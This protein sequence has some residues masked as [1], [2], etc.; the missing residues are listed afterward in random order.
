MAN[1]L[2]PQTPQGAT[3]L[4]VPS[5][6][7]ILASP[8]STSNSSIGVGGG[9]RPTLKS[10][11]SLLTFAPNKQTTPASSA[12]PNAG[13]PS[14]STKSPFSNFGSVRRSMNLSREKGKV[15][16][17]ERK[18][19]WSSA[20]PVIAI[21]HPSSTSI[22]VTPTPVRKSL[23]LSTFDKST[24]E[25]SRRILTINNDHR[26]S[27]KQPVEFEALFND[28]KPLP[29]T[30]SSPQ[31]MDLSTIIEADTSGISKHLPSASDS[32]P[33]SPSRLPSQSPSPSPFY[34]PLSHHVTD[35]NED[36]HLEL[37]LSTSQITSQVAYEWLKDVNARVVDVDVDD[38]LPLDDDAGPPVRG[39]LIVNLDTVD[40]ALAALLS[41]HKI[42]PG[43][44]PGHTDNENETIVL[45][46]PVR[47]NYPTLSPT[48]QVTTATLH[49]L[50]QRPQHQSSLP[51]LRP[52]QYS[53]SSP[54][55]AADILK[56]TS[57]DD[58]KNTHSQNQA[59]IH[60]HLQEH[61]SSG[62]Q[63][64]SRSG[65]PAPAF[66]SGSSV[67]GRLLPPSANPPTFTSNTSALSSS[68][69]S[70]SAGHPTPSM[71]TASLS[72]MYHRKGAT[73]SSLH[74]P[75]D[76]AT[77]LNMHVNSEIDSTSPVRRHQRRNLGLGLP[78]SSSPSSPLSTR[79]P[80]VETPARR[81]LDSPT[82]SPRRPYHSTRLAERPRSRATVNEHGELI[83]GRG[84]L[85]L[86]PS[87]RIITSHPARSSTFEIRRQR[88]RSM[89][90]EDHSLFSSLGRYP[91]SRSGA[92][93]SGTSRPEARPSSSL[94]FKHTDETRSSSRPVTEWLGPRTAKAFRAA[95]LLGHDQDGEDSPSLGLT[96]TR[97]YGSIR[98][99][100]SR[101]QSGT[102]SRIEGQRRGSGSYFS[103][104]SAVGM[105]SP[106][107]TISSSRGEREWPPRSASTAP[108]SVSGISN[109]REREREK[110]ES[111]FETLKEK[112]AVET[113]ALLSALADSQRTTKVLREENE[114]LRE[115]L[116]EAQRL[117][118]VCDGLRGELARVEGENE[119]LKQF[120][121]DYVVREGD[122]GMRSNVELDPRRRTQVF[123]ASKG[124][125]G[126][127]AGT[128]SFRQA[129]R[130]A[131]PQSPSPPPTA[132]KD[133]FNL[134]EHPCEVDSNREYVTS[135]STPAANRKSRR[136]STASS[137]IF[138]APPANMTMLNEEKLAPSAD[139]GGY[140]SQSESDASG[141]NSRSIPWNAKSNRDTSILS[142]SNFSVTT[143]SPSSLC[144]RPE[145]E[146]HLGD[147]DS[148]DFG[149]GVANHG[150]SGD[151]E[152]WQ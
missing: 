84:S 19:S 152:E 52:H 139:I 137:S 111:A 22:E 146:L 44:V 71:S 148:L 41:P 40:P 34:L 55:L 28:S 81:S 65:A 147:M 48:T 66:S 144:L 36:S 26:G 31:Q 64:T 87:P 43:P 35:V 6:S 42:P 119:R 126:R 94:S 60:K 99:T 109:G 56:P 150:E 63:S 53:S 79:K 24:E 89:S 25:D 17:R 103:G 11:R 14:G 77:S 95:G 105:E 142:I 75:S 128:G 92:G 82:T 78:F 15:Q 58:V 30:P 135:T 132:T 101:T 110:E 72:T 62:H 1:S 141:S 120:V 90:V 104:A 29:V 102:Q 80:D 140:L 106:T 118:D 54:A 45:P 74:N 13:T 116:Q 69:T 16:E 123:L 112:H 27:Q 32:T 23:S 83:L 127:H 117:E 68:S 9:S 88:K 70:P 4:P 47:P 107:Y 49:D 3:R 37:E 5:T 138:P 85:D 97:R 133:S 10:L 51:R 149:V 61:K 96:Q 76:S 67:T 100:T 33:P 98:S 18:L 129:L 115:R 20:M 136:F 131:A 38:S 145:H 125:L 130:I 143:G 57:D 39:S 93:S 151:E 50:S 21:D 113:S 134:E 73:L 8:A 114:E 59:Q 2:F 12:S 46:D 7:R 108:T 91:G 86:E 124:S 122:T 121:A